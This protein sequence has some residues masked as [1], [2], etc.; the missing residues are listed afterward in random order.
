M[1]PQLVTVTGKAPSVEV[2]AAAVVDPAGAEPQL[3]STPLST[4]AAAASAVAR[5]ARVRRWRG[6]VVRG[7]AMA[8][9][10]IKYPVKNGSCECAS[11]GRGAG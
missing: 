11:G 1:L 5:R 3:V 6:R 4:T 7:G 8:V 9:L 10:S 2:E